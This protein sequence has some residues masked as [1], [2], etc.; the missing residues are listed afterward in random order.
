MTLDNPNDLIL[1]C[2]FADIE[3]SVIANALN[4]IG[5]LLMENQKQM[6]FDKVFPLSLDYLQ[7]HLSHEKR[8]LINAFEYWIE[9]MGWRDIY[10]DLKKRFRQFLK[11]KGKDL[12]D[13]TYK[14]F[15]EFKTQYPFKE[16]EREILKC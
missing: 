13:Y 12:T 16:E 1:G 2:T 9:E 7:K 8:V 10:E 4:A 15:M 11:E 5:K 14:D 3:H 6:V